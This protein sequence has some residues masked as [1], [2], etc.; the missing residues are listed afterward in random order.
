MNS[1]LVLVSR[2]G[3]DDSNG[4]AGRRSDYDHGCSLERGAEES[5]GGVAAVSLA[6]E[7]AAEGVGGGVA[8]VV[9]L[10]EG[11]K[12]LTVQLQCGKPR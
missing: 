6:A 2:G 5:A 7:D 10:I 8:V 11:K 9:D 1:V 4:G 3:R 12:G